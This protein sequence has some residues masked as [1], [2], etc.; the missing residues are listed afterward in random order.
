MS[1]PYSNINQFLNTD[2]ATIWDAIN[3]QSGGGGNPGQ[4]IDLSRGF[5]SEKFNLTPG[6]QILY[7]SPLATIDSFSSIR[8]SLT[9]PP[10][11]GQRRVIMNL[12]DV[13]SGNI[14]HSLVSPYIQDESKSDYIFTPTQFSP[15]TF[16][17]AGSRHF[18]LPLP[19]EVGVLSTQTDDQNNF[20]Y[21]LRSEIEGFDPMF[22]IISNFVLTYKRNPYQ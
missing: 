4:V 11:G 5:V 12:Y 10:G 16:V 17:T 2:L 3:N 8:F 15:A 18:V 22:D 13:T 1:L 7:R 14:V 21:E 9:I 19:S 6:N 20:L